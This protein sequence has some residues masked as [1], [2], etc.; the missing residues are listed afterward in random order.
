MATPRE[1]TARLGADGAAVLAYLRGEPGAVGAGRESAI[2]LSARL[3]DR[4]AK[5]V[6]GTTHGVMD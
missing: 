6:V 2:D 4:P 1:V 5:E 3:P